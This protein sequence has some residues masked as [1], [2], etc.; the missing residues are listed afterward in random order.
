MDGADTY[1]V[2]STHSRPKAAGA[3]EREYDN[4]YNVSTHSRPK[5]AGAKMYLPSSVL[6]SFQHTAARRRLESK[7]DL[8]R[9][10]RV[11]QHTAA[12]RRLVYHFA[13]R[14]LPGY[15]STHSCP[16]AAG[17][18]TAQRRSNRRCFNT[19]PPEGGWVKI[20]VYTSCL[21]LFQH[22]AARR[23][24]AP[25]A[26]FRAYTRPFQHTAARRRLG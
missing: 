16:K 24:L 7:P 13:R 4:I 11:F 5:A 10:I 3:K 20:L 6:N 18:K 14:F 8:E 1:D 22:T 17:K 12:R 19:Q 25:P 9:F 23:R 15:V 26:R 2:V 21:F